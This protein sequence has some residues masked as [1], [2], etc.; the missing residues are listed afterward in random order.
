LNVER[1]TTTATRP[2]WIK[3][4][5]WRILAIGM[6]LFVA[7]ALIELGLR[8]LGVAPPRLLSKRLL[9]DT[10][11]QPLIDYHCY[12]QNSHGEFSQVPDVTDGHWRLTDF[13]KRDYALDELAKTPWCVE[14]RR[15]PQ[16]LRDREYA[17]AQ[18]GDPL[19]IACVGD[20]FVFGEGVPLE[21]TLPRQ[22]EQLLGDKFQVI[23]AGQPGWGTAEELS[24]ARRLVADLGV[25]RVVLVF[26]ANDILLSDEL[27]ARENALHDLINVR[28]ELIR[29]AE[30]ERWNARGLR[31]LEWLRTYTTMQVISEQTIQWYLD[32]YDPTFNAAG[33]EWLDEHLRAF[34]QIPDCQVAVVLYPLLEQ[35]ERDY[36]L[37]PIYDRVQA[38]AEAAG[39]P[40][41]N[42]TTEFRGS[43]TADQWVDP[44]DHHP[45]GTAHRAAATAIADWLPTIPGFLDAANGRRTVSESK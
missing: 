12:P 39:L 24:A 33:L 18:P 6:G 28:D 7:C 23:N 32:A 1:A 27:R 9:I 44:S 5:L 38:M 11:S 17:T 37:Q 2:S 13:M 21:R 29:T 22:L 26:T 31:L 40:V 45:N 35:L 30:F 25:N 14:Y 42:L 36:P 16:G 19:R 43:A 41:L 10:D 4:L 8:V 15:S 34:A 20:S 3:G